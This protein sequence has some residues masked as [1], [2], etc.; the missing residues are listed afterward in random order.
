MDTIKC[1]RCGTPVDESKYPPGERLKCE[2][3]G[4]SER[5]YTVEI[6]ENIKLSDH[7]AM[8]QKRADANIGFGE[9][10]R[11]GLASFG[12]LEEDGTLR[13]GLQGMPPQGEHDTLG[14]CQRLI[15]RLNEQDADWSPLTPGEDDVDCKS[16]S[17]SDSARVLRIQVVRAVI[18]PEFW[19]SLATARQASYQKKSP[20]DLALELPT[21]IM[22]KEERISA[23]QREGLVLAL[24]ATRL[25]AHAL[26]AVLGALRTRLS[27]LHGFGFKE[28]WLVGPAVSMTRAYP[29]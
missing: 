9:G 5:K 11:E 22:H 17:E 16:E 20:D 24:D 7:C 1:A 18:D 2:S 10:A 15:T 23:C 4:S 12:F 27:S 19:R 14:T 13:Y 25:P 28:I 6:N 21:A 8:L 26:D 29:E 3:C